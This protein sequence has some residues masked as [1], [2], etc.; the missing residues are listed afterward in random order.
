MDKLFSAFV[1][2][3]NGGEKKEYSYEDFQQVLNSTPLFMRET[4][5]QITEEN[6]YVLEALKS[7]A[8]E[9]DGDGERL[10]IR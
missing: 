3:A 9:G 2:A 5:D 6:S 8:F 7:L 1:N 4:P 10:L